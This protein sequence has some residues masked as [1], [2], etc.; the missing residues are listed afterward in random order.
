MQVRPFFT[1]DFFLFFYSCPFL[2]SSLPLCGGPYSNR[3]IFIYWPGTFIT[4]TSHN[5]VLAVLVLLS[6]V[7]EYSDASQIREQIFWGYIPF[8]TDKSVAAV[9]FSGRLRDLVIQRFEVSSNILANN[10]L[11]NRSRLKENFWCLA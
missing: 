4:V 10:I 9:S 6:C 7:V 11:S 3:V 8:H 2:L 5:V 1:V